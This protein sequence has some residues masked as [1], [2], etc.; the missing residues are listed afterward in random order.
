VGQKHQTIT[1]TVAALTVLENSISD[2]EELHETLLKVA[3]LGPEILQK[4][5]KFDDD[6]EGYIFPPVVREL[7]D[8][9]NP[10]FGAAQALAEEKWVRV[11]HKYARGLD[12]YWQLRSLR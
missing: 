3:D 8:A 2:P 11:L 10:V 6:P 7:E 9:E 4:V 1:A 5:W 12:N